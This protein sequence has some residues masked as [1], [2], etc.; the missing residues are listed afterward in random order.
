M[1]RK[2]TAITLSLLIVSTIGCTLITPPDVDVPPGSGNGVI[3]PAPQPSTPPKHPDT[4]YIG[5]DSKVMVS[6]VDSI[7][8]LV[9]KKRNLP[10]TYVPVDLSRAD[11][12]F[13]FDGDHPRM[14]LREEAARALEDLFDSAAT[15]GLELYATSGYRS[16]ETQ[17]AIFAANV[18]KVGEEEANKTSAVPGQSEHQ[19]GLAMDVTSAVVNYRLV[20]SFGET[21]EGMWLAQNAHH[22]GFIIRY[23]KGKE[24]ITGYSYEPWHVRYVGTEAAK[25]IFPRA[26]TLEEY[27]LYGN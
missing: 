20:E 17:A 8:V 21:E 16:Y 6:N 9:N 15:A 1:S 23:P 13:P 7:L 18:A 27:I 19:T 3:F 4:I 12:P 25:L 26:L 2:I 11:V 5:E 24:D 14:Y 10:A 22:F